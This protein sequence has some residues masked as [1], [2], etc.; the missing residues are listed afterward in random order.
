MGKQPAANKSNTKKASTEKNK[1]NYFQ[2][3]QTP[4]STIDKSCCIVFKKQ[5]VTG[6]QKISCSENSQRNVHDEVQLW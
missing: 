6:T 3:F 4:L 5:V 2:V 1:M